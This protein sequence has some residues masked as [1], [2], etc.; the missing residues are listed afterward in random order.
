MTLMTGEETDWTDERNRLLSV[1]LTLLESESCGNCGT[2]S[3][4]GHSTNNEISFEVESS[5]C[6]GCAEL[7]KSNE[8]EQRGRK[9]RGRGEMKY[10]VPRMAWEDQQIPSRFDL[11]SAEEEKAR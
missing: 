6:F 10:V 7:E 8:D 5:T 4:I 11:Y 1:A 2:P 9:K 3:W